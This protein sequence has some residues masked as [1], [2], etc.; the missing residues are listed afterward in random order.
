[1]AACPNTTFSSN[2]NTTPDEKCKIYHPLKLFYSLNNLR[3]QENHK[4]LS[5]LNP[6]QEYYLQPC[7][8]NSLCQGP[9]CLKQNEKIIPIGD[10][11]TSEYFMD[12]RE[13][14]I[15]YKSDEKCLD[16]KWMKYSSEIR[17]VCDHSDN[18]DSIELVGNVYMQYEL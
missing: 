4:I 16:L 10:I 6:K 11:D 15:N 12:E 18:Q 13:I 1:M 3:S 8:A 5:K 2:Q 7:G 17:F 9:I 14:R